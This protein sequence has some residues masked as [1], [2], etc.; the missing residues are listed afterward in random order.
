M[1]IDPACDERTRRRPALIPILGLKGT[2][3]ALAVTTSVS[4]QG[5]P[6]SR[7]RVRQPPAAGALAYDSARARVVLFASEV[8][9]QAMA[10]LVPFEWDGEHWMPRFSRT[11]VATRHGFSAAPTA[12]GSL[13]VF[14]GRGDYEGHGPFRG[15]TIAWDGQ[16]WHVHAPPRSPSPRQLHLM[17]Y[18]SQ[19][20]R[21][22]LT[23]GVDD[24]GRRLNDVWEWDGAQWHEQSAAAPFSHPGTMAYDAARQRMV[25]V[26]P[27]GAHVQTW[28]WDGSTWTERLTR[29]SP[30]AGVAALCYDVG[31]Q[32]C[33]LATYALPQLSTWDWDGADWSLVSTQ[34]EYNVTAASIAFDEARGRPVLLGSFEY[35]SPLLE[36]SEG[37]WRRATPRHPLNTWTHFGA[38]AT[39]HPLR[40]KVFLLESLSQRESLSW[41]WDGRSWWPI[42]GSV[43]PRID[44]HTMTYDVA[45]DRIVVFGDGSTS[46]TWEWDGTQWSL[47]ASGVPSNRLASLAYDAGRSRVVLFGGSWN[48]AYSD[49]WEWDGTT[50]REM[51]TSVR[52][53]AGYQPLVYDAARRVTTCVAYL[54]GQSM[55]TWTWDGLEWQRIVPPFASPPGRRMPALAYDSERQLVLLFGGTDPSGTS[56]FDDL[57]EWDGS[58]WSMSRLAMFSG[59]SPRTTATMT[60]DPVRRRV[61][62]FGGI[63]HTTGGGRTRKDVWELGPNDEASSIPFGVGCATA[64]TPP[65]LPATHTAYV[66]NADFG[67]DVAGVAPNAPLWLCVGARPDAQSVGGQCRVLIRDIVQCLPLVADADGRARLTC[68][69]PNERGL[70]GIQAFCQGLV[71]F[72]LQLTDGLQVTIGCR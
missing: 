71:P 1:P 7:W 13:L 2:M 57:W 53:P 5:E 43:Q 36:W 59:P 25:M 12:D 46:Q 54:P 38:S 67:V 27:A 37:I 56:S 72:P 15:D 33:R 11:Q 10:S 61:F 31:R 55:Q 58:N 24:T 49:T 70:V 45:R 6:L 52:P 35:G 3:I 62:L 26:V 19:R 29:T 17:A 68:P 47:V 8:G 50:W 65:G 42:A 18:D 21:T 28:E 4:G 20:R 63:E 48:R 51:P 14:G 32:R 23:G 41:E 40:R 64:G 30:S 66:G 60:H 9:T 44:A 22:V 16:E 39:F 34:S 69:I